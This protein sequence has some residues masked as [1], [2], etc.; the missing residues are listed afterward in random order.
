MART[1]KTIEAHLLSAAGAQIYPATGPWGHALTWWKAAA[2]ISPALPLGLA[3][4]LGALLTGAAL[5]TDDTNEYAAFL[6][7]VTDTPAARSARSL[8]LCDIAVAALLA[9]LAQDAPIPA[10]YRIPSSGSLAEIAAA[11][12]SALAQPPPATQGPAGNAQSALLS[13]HMLAHIQILSPADVR[14]VA[15]LGQGVMG[16]ADLA[17]LRALAELLSLPAMSHVLLDEVLA[18]LPAMA[19][20]APGA[21]LQTYAVDGYGGLAH[22][23]SL[24]AVVSSEWALPP[25]LLSYRYLN[26]ELLYY[27]R[28][29]PPERM[30]TL[31]LLL[32]QLSDATAGD[33]EPLLKASAL[34]MARAGQARGETVAV[35]TF[36]TQLHQPHGL[37]R[38]AEVADLVRQSGR[39]GADLGRVL[40]QVALQVRAQAQQYP[41]IELLWLLHAQAGADQVG[42]VTALARDL[43]AQV[44]SRAL[45]VSAGA[46]VEQPALAGALA[47]QWV[48][49]GS[50]ALHTAEERA[51]AARALRGLA[52]QS[53][54]ERLAVA[55]LAPQR[56][57]VLVEAS[58]P[59]DPAQ[60][61]LDAGQW[62]VALA[63]LEPRASI[64]D[65]S[66]KRLLATM[67][68]G[69]RMACRRDEEGQEG[70]IPWGMALPPL[71]FR[72]KAAA[73]LGATGDPR[74]LDPQCG[75][76][77]LGG[78]WCP[79]KAGP[80][81]HG[82]EQYHELTRVSLHYPYRLG[83][84]PVTNAEYRR[85]ID[86]GGY[87]RQQWWTEHGWQHRSSRTHPHHWDD[88]RYS[89]PTQPVV[90]ITWWEC[91]AYCAWVTEV[92]RAAGWLPKQ[93]QIRLPTALEWER[94]ARGITLQRYPWGDAEPDS[95]RANYKQTGIGRPSPVGCFPTGAAACGAQDMAGN[96]MEWMCT[97]SDEPDQVE[98]QPD[99]SSDMGVLMSLSDYDD[100]AEH[101]SCGACYWDSPIDWIFIRSFRIVWSHLIL[102]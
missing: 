16:V 21:A 51:K 32:L 30:S 1:T 33:L 63:A 39:G 90:G 89:Q 56:R 96:V 87:Q 86:A 78:Y 40:G 26:G 82:D 22:A 18:F 12:A 17:D 49:V 38:P 53:D 85:F 69:D 36:D 27:G 83:R 75:D 102:G 9:H 67:V 61:L 13:T 58:P 35:A 84:Y 11:L 5:P 59:P 23:G 48:S 76:A 72:L 31:L 94:A 95:E 91:M 24:G 54:R 7:A 42:A 92:G 62:K 8:G 97:A 19:E 15:D 20:S 100:S 4:D 25:A 34:A 29:R 41:R 6:C 68:E 47:D 99:V 37:R 88:P 101:L 64:G 28:E 66:A 10:E 80:F 70:A 73:V 3:A 77:P 60:P 43:R 65:D 71:E 57:V 46:G 52:K 2:E 79:V 55:P 98:A 74:L 93:D 14:F 81:W 50:A 44:G 45:F